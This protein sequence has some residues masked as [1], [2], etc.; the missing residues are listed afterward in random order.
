VIIVGGTFEVEPHQREEFL[1]GRHEMMRTS[2]AEEGCLEYTFSADPL[3]PGRVLLFERW[4]SQEALDVHLSSLR[5]AP[6]P[7]GTEVAPK[8]A[9]IMLYEVSGERP[10]R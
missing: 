2:R 10:L 5:A 3:D 7:S 1:A 8:A 4:A 6:G 9:S